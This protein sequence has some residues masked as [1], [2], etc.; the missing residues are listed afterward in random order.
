MVRGNIR[1]RPNIRGIRNNFKKTFVPRHPFDQTLAEMVFPKVTTAVPDDSA[2]TN[3]REFFTCVANSFAIRSKLRGVIIENC[4][5]LQALLKRNQDLS[6]NAQEQT[7]IANLV[8][9]VQ[10]VLD[11]LVVAPGEFTTCVSFLA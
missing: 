3:V 8:T 5:F 6:P 7:A 9:K 10:G 11:N 4:L 2:L 1:G